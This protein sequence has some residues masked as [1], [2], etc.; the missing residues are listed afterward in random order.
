LF[1]KVEKPLGY[2]I[3]EKGNPTKRKEQTLQ[4]KEEKY[5]ISTKR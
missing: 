2:N 3:P 5:R 4:T 1:F